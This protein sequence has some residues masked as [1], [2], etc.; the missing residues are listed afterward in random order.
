MG[1]QSIIAFS[2]ARFGLRVHHKWIWKETSAD[3]NLSS[4]YSDKMSFHRPTQSRLMSLRRFRPS[5]SLNRK[6][7]LPAGRLVTFLHQNDPGTSSLIYEMIADVL[8]C[9]SPGSNVSSRSTRFREQGGERIDDGNVRT[10]K[11]Q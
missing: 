11:M 6:T 1:I 8:L 10:V 2:D 7:S 9:V 3:V 5:R 4:A